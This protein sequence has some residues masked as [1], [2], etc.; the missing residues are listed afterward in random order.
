MRVDT[1]FGADFSLDG[2]TWDEIPSTVTVPGPA[3]TVT[4]R[5]AKVSSSAADGS[6]D[7]RYLRVDAVLSAEARSTT[8]HVTAADILDAGRHGT[9]ATVVVALAAEGRR[10]GARPRPGPAGRGAIRVRSSSPPNPS[11]GSCSGSP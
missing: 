4:V 5:E 9:F 10:Q 1:T 7:L 2:A 3:T 8:C 6:S 11:A